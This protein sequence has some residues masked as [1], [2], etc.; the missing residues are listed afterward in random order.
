MEYGL[1]GTIIIYSKYSR[2]FLQVVLH[3]VWYCEFSDMDV[4][5]KERAATGVL[6][7]LRSLSFL[8]SPNQMF[9]FLNDQVL[10]KLARQ[11]HYTDGH[12]THG[13][14]KFN[15]Y[16]ESLCDMRVLGK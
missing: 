7:L 6:A 5:E 10:K 4:C 3:L 1:Y 12:L 14:H 15:T 16:F 2:I 11:L 8:T 9:S 13:C